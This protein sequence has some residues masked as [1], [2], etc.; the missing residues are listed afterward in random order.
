MCGELTSSVVSDFGNCTCV[1]FLKSQPVN[2]PSCRLS[3]SSAVR[4]A[5]RIGQLKSLC[6]MLIDCTVD[7]RKLWKLTDPLRRLLATL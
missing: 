1:S 6:A 7:D 4:C 2:P 5:S 3:C